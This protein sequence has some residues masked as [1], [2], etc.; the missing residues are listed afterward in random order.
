MKLQVAKEK[1]VRKLQ[2]NGKETVGGRQAKHCKQWK[3]V[4]WPWHLGTLL[5]F[6]EVTSTVVL[7]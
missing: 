1:R 3:R 5:P 7:Q 4:Q 6:S 2:F